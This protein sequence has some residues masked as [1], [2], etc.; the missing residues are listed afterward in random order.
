[1]SKYDRATVRAV[2]DLLLV[3]GCDFRDNIPNNYGSIRA[4]MFTGDGPATQFMGEA[5]TA[6]YAVHRNGK[7]TGEYEQRATGYH[8]INDA[9]VQR[10]LELLHRHDQI[11]TN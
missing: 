7:F 4:T 1:M 6:Q 5:K 8:R 11:P 10:V 2:L 3:E 9:G